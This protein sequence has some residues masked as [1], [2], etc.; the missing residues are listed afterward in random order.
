MKC[1]DVGDPAL[2]EAIMPLLMYCLIIAGPIYIGLQHYKDYIRAQK[3]ICKK[4]SVVY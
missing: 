1:Y 2:I 4:V 3:W